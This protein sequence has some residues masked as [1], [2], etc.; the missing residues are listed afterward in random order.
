[1]DIAGF[2]QIFD[3]LR[4]HIC[5]LYTSDSIMPMDSGIDEKGFILIRE[6]STSSWKIDG[7]GEPYFCED[8]EILL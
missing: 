1:L 5:L 2:V 6:N 8:E 3:C 7:A 4:P